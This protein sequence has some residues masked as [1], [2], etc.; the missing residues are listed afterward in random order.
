MKGLII[1]SGNINNYFFLKE[2]IDKHDFI[3][4]VDGGIDHVIDMDIKINLIIGDL[5]S[6]SKKGLN[7]IEE[8]NI[9]VERHPII[10]NKT[11]TELAVSW[12]IERKFS[13]I[14]M[15]GVIGSRMDHTLANIYLLKY[16]FDN[17]IDG[18]II[19][20]NNIIRYTD[21]FIKLKK[22]DG[23]NVSVIPV[24]NEGCIISLKGFLYELN[25]AHIPFASTLGISNKMVEDQGTILV[26]KGQILVTESKD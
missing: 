8:K 26:E 9:E 22:I 16:I 18:K 1:A 25:K 6:I 21:S 5:D 19:D 13:E 3:L 14:T 7:Y 17:N 24:S 11:D 15:V 2:L 12:M 4:C 10:K 20:E 23:Y